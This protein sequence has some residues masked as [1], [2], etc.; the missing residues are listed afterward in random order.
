[1]WENIVLLTII[2]VFYLLLSA[3]AIQYTDSETNTVHIYGIG[4]MRARV[5]KSIEGVK[6]IAIG[7]D[8]IGISISKG[9]ELGSGISL[10]F[11]SKSKIQVSDNT[12]VRLEYPKKGLFTVHV[13]TIP[14]INVINPNN[15]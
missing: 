3:C 15:Q 14:P 10:G 13:G 11:E 6:V 8:I 4:H 5:S 7:Q 1:M 9:G 2:F 12:S